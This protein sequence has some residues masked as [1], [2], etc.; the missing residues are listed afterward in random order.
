M[1]LLVTCAGCYSYDMPSLDDV[2][3]D[4]A[5]EYLPEAGA[6]LISPDGNVKADGIGADEVLKYVFEVFSDAFR[7][8]VLP[9]F[10]VLGII[11]ICALFSNYSQIIRGGTQIRIYGFLSA[12]CLG[13]TLSGIL[14]DIWRSL[15]ALG[16]KLV[17]LINAVSGS[18][19]TVYAISGSVTE[20]AVSRTD[21]AVFTG[22]ISEIFGSG[23]FPVLEICFAFSFISAVSDLID[24]DSFSALI[25]RIYTSVIV[26][27]MGILTTVLSVSH[28]LSSRVDNATV[29]GIKMAAGSFI[30][31]VG[32]AIGEASRTVA[33]GTDLLKSSLGV[34]CLI[35]LAAC[36][37]PL[38]ARM[39]VTKLSLLLAAAFSDLLGLKRE[40][41]FI[42]SSASLLNFSIALIASVSTVFVI[43]LM[44]FAGSSAV[45]GG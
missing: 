43:N 15:N 29:R 32:N 16:E 21:L 42:R 39:L 20:A 23:L 18:I 44:I 30:P 28:V 1:T 9:L 12:L 7:S 26:F 3:P 25:R 35:A 33:A 36:V 6:G 17:T 45:T 38:I 4:E 22:V 19:V 2:L 10:S 14:T 13:V 11:V 34:I 40:A 41:G 24:L 5:R 8:S 27:I 37:L 31:I